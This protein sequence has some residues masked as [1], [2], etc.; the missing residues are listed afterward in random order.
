MNRSGHGRLYDKFDKYGR[1]VGKV[2]I[3]GKDVNLEQLLAGM[4]WFYLCVMR[5]AKS[6]PAFCFLEFTFYTFTRF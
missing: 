6:L 5:L 2:L 1:V 3:D 4:A